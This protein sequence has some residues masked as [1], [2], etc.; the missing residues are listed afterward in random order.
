MHGTARRNQ[1]A[2]T[3]LT[4]PSTRLRAFL[5]LGA[6]LAVVAAGVVA[7]AGTAIASPAQVRAVAY[8]LTANLTAGQ[9]IPAV[10]APAA[11]GGQFSGV[12]L[13]SGV[14]AAKV[15]ALAG[16]KVVT[17]PRSSGL[18]TRFNCVGSVVRVPAVPG[19]WRL[20]WRLSYSGLSGPA[21]RVDIHQAPAG[22]AAPPAYALCGPCHSVPL[23]GKSVT[24]GSMA[25]TAD[26][27]AALN[28]NA[29]VNVDTA[30]NPGGEIRG[31]IK[32]AAAARLV[33]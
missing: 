27:A 3:V 28:G 22:H 32:R 14:G 1:D 31:Q 2:R 15:A 17:P 5:P 9:Q 33:A 23:S 4:K 20:M 16:C 30:A 25:L 10:Q 12:L 7:T 21:T 19:Q 24:H 18:P 11:A 13:K 29:Y 8:R 26:Q 6:A